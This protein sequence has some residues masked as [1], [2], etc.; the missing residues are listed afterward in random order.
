MAD[1]DPTFVDVRL[2][3]RSALVLMDWLQTHDE[4]SLPFSDPAEKQ[5]LRDL[6]SALE[7]SLGLGASEAELAEARTRVARDMADEDRV[8]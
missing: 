8:L 7:W 6:L 5:A 3:D 2:W 1:A 4:A